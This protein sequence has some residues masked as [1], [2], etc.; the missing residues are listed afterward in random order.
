MTIPYYPKENTEEVSCSRCGAS[1]RTQP[2]YTPPD[3][4]RFNSQDSI[5]PT[6]DEDE[7]EVQGTPI[8]LCWSCWCLRDPDDNPGPPSTDQRDILVNPEA[9][10]GA[11]LRQVGME[12]VELQATLDRIPRKVSHAIP[13]QIRNSLLAGSA[14][15]LGFGLG[16]VSGGGKTSTLSALVLAYLVNRLRN[17]WYNGQPSIHDELAWVSWPDQ[18]ATWRLNGIASDIDYKVKSFGSVRIL[19]LD[20]I[21]REPDRGDFT[22][23][24]ALGH[25][26]RVIDIRNRKNL[27]TFWT[28]NFNDE[29][30]VDRYGGSMHRRLVDLNPLIFIPGLEFMSRQ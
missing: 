22:K 12:A 4:Y 20:D 19:V 17:T 29:Q 6:F 8:S 23:D 24:T 21:G 25:L 9:W 18:Y 2:I 10:A 27:P 30:L 5:W 28:T 7:D 14:P 16:G 26:A 3:R 13:M 1:N 15:M 11:A